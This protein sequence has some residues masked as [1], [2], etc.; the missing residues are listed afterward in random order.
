MGLGPFDKRVDPRLRGN[1]GVIGSHLGAKSNA[2]RNAFERKN[3]FFF[4]PTRRDIIFQVARASN[5]FP[6]VLKRINPWHD[7]RFYRT[8]IH[9]METIFPGRLTHPPNFIIS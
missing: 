1:D 6:R 2:L 7:V 9:V 8:H 5:A 4:L 3:F